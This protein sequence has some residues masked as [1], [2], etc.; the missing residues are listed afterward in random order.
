MTTRNEFNYLVA[1]PH[2]SVTPLYRV[3]RFNLDQSKTDVETLL[4]LL[5]NSYPDH[6]DDLND[7][8]LRKVR[9]FTGGPTSA[10]TST[11]GQWSQL[12]GHHQGRPGGGLQLDPK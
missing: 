7:A 9:S 10:L 11:T 12:D 8:I 3:K 2:P 4:G 6:T 1:Y 5:K